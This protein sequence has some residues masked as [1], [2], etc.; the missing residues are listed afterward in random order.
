MDK[1]PFIGT[2]AQKSTAAGPHHEAVVCVRRKIAIKPTNYYKN[3][4]PK[5]RSATYSILDDGL[6]CFVVVTLL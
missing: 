5:V 6:L 2:P 1:S 3:I 4:K